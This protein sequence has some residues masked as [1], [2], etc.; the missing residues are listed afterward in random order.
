MEKVINLGSSGVGTGE[1]L[2]FAANNLP[3]SG[4]VL[5][6]WALSELVA[7]GHKNFTGVPLNYLGIK[8]SEIIGKI[9]GTH[10]DHLNILSDSDY[11]ELLNHSDEEFPKF[12]RGGIFTNPLRGIIGEA[13][14]EAVIPLDGKVLGQL[15]DRI[16]MSFYEKS[17]I[18]GSAKRYTGYSSKEISDKGIADTVGKKIKDTF[19][20]VYKV[21]LMY[22]QQTANAVSKFVI[23]FKK[24][25]FMESLV[26]FSSNFQEGFKPTIEMAK[27]YFNVAKNY[28]KVG[29][30]KDIEKVQKLYHKVNL[31]FEKG[32]FYFYRNFRNQ[33][34]RRNQLLYDKLHNWVIRA[35]D[36]L[37]SSFKSFTDNIPGHLSSFGNKIVSAFKSF[38]SKENQDKFEKG[39]RQS[40]K[41]LNETYNN[42]VKSS[43]ETSFNLYHGIKSGVATVKS[44]LQAER[45]KIKENEYQK[46]GH[47]TAKNKIKHFGSGFVEYIGPDTTMREYLTKLTILTGS[48][49]EDLFVESRN[50]IKS[51]IKMINSTSKDSSLN[52]ARFR[53]ITE[54]HFSTFTVR[55]AELFKKFN[56]SNN[57]IG[58][59]FGARNNFLK[60]ILLKP[61]LSTL[62]KSMPGIGLLAGPLLAG[63][64]M[65]NKDWRGANIELM[66]GIAGGMGIAPVSAMLSAILHK[67][68]FKYR[69]GV[70][71][72]RGIDLETDRE[73]ALED[74]DG[75][76]GRATARQRDRRKSRIKHEREFIRTLSK[77]TPVLG[78]FAGA[79]LSAKRLIAGDRFGAAA[80]LASGVAGGIGMT[81][82]SL[83]ISGATKIP[84]I[85]NYTKAGLS[86][87]DVALKGIL[88]TRYKEETTK[89]VLKFGLK[90]IPIIGAVAGGAFAARRL[91]KGDKVGAGL[92]LVGGL[93]GGLGGPLGGAMIEGA[94]PFINFMAT[95]AAGFIQ[96]MEPVASL[97]KPISSVWESIGGLGGIISG[98]FNIPFDLS[99]LKESLDTYFGVISKGTFLGNIIDNIHTGTKV[100]SH[101]IGDFFSSSVGLMDKGIQGMSEVVRT[102]FVNLFDNNMVKGSLKFLQTFAPISNFFSATGLGQLSNLALGP[103]DFFR[104]Q[105]ED[106]FGK[107]NKKS[108]GDRFKNFI[109]SFGEKKGPKISM[110]DRIRNYQQRQ[111]DI[112]NED[113]LKI[114]KT[115]DGPKQKVGFIPSFLGSIAGIDKSGKLSNAISS[116]MNFMNKEIKFPSIGKDFSFGKFIKSGRTK[117]D[118]F[119]RNITEIDNPVSEWG[120]SDELNTEQT[121]SKQKGSDKLNT[122]QTSSK[123]KGSFKFSMPKLRMPKISHP[124]KNFKFPDI[125]KFSNKKLDDFSERLH[126]INNPLF[127]RLIGDWDG[128]ERSH[129]INNPLFK[130]LIG[131]WDGD[132]KLSTDQT[133]SE[134]KEKTQTKP[135]NIFKLPTLSSL[136]KFNLL[137]SIRTKVKDFDRYVTVID[138]PIGEWG[139]APLPQKKQIPSKQKDSF[140]L[141]DMKKWFYSISSLGKRDKEEQKNEARNRLR[142]KQRNLD[143]VGAPRYMGGVIPLEEDASYLE[144]PMKESVKEGKKLGEKVKNF[145]ASIRESWTNGID[146]EIGKRFDAASEAGIVGS[147]SSSSTVGLKGGLRSLPFLSLA[148]STVFAGDRLNKGDFR[149]A[150]LEMMIGLAGASGSDGG[151]FIEELRQRDSAI[152]GNI[153]ETKETEPKGTAGSIIK[154]WQKSGKEKRNKEEKKKKKPNELF[155]WLKSGVKNTGKTKKKTETSTEVTPKTNTTTTQTTNVI[156]D[157]DAQVRDVTIAT[158]SGKGPA[159]ITKDSVTNVTPEKQKGSQSKFT[160]G[161]IFGKFKGVP[162]KIKQGILGPLFS[163]IIGEVIGGAVT[164]EILRRASKKASVK[165]TKQVAGKGFGG[166]LK[167]LFGGI[168][169]WL[170]SSAVIKGIKGLF[171]AKAAKTVGVGV[172]GVAGKGLTFAAMG[173]GLAAVA[174]GIGT[175]VAAI[176]TA[177]AWLIALGVAALTGGGL[178]LNHIS[179]EKRDPNIQYRKGMPIVPTDYS[180]R[181]TN[182]SNSS[183]KNNNFAN[184]LLNIIAPPAYASEMSSGTL[185]NLTQR[186]KLIAQ[187]NASAIFKEGERR[188]TK[189]FFGSI[190]NFFTSLFSNSSDELDKNN[191]ATNIQS[192]APLVG[193]DRLKSANVPHLRGEGPHDITM[194]ELIGLRT[195]SELEGTLHSD[196]SRTIV[197]GGLAS[198][199]NDHPRKLTYV[200]GLGVYSDAAGYGQFLSPTWDQFGY[201]NFGE[202]NQAQAMVSL[203]HYRGLGQPLSD[204]MLH[205]IT[206]NQIEQLSTEWASVDGGVHGQTDYSFDDRFPQEYTR[207]AQRAIWELDNLPLEEIRFVPHPDSMI[208]KSEDAPVETQPQNNTVVAPVIN[209]TSTTPTGGEFKTSYTFAPL[210]HESSI[211]WAETFHL[212]KLGMG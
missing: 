37:E 176:S 54:S 206:S 146:K 156:V 101:L 50:M 83:A 23:A 18:K 168:A 105:G 207:Q 175:V 114:K 2:A 173:K 143:R 115:L 186:D 127:K 147:I 116:S 67:R 102:G 120:G 70:R 98:V 17:N 151:K 77:A 33:L 131:E 157:E 32:V 185:N 189:G 42:V 172:A 158:D 27:E 144:Q 188:N 8:S 69:K 57:R 10:K 13:G 79:R 161:K 109:W 119:D 94:V 51:G 198:N 26:K 16:V 47:G 149:G 36:S 128:D 192:N 5:G 113:M 187:E 56:Q 208:F 60:D 20:E 123:Q 203:M 162:D 196:G 112:E 48:V 166:L 66:S 58:K 129:S 99:A 93:A 210:R 133:P 179:G 148:L 97:L 46:F 4:A 11:I 95:E 87:A 145:F 212:Q 118:K 104:G 76:A 3:I 170:G 82:L 22:I 52:F 122:D 180:S 153:D 73:L 41:R 1:A 28:V 12:A 84:N 184:S 142:A 134:Q 15:A 182:I 195:I 181:K 193:I 164:G 21:P 167:G 19:M 49:V 171:A 165:A 81:P 178:Y 154:G 155:G 43:I 111:L 103:L 191:S 202:A 53:K 141:P 126:S 65:A 201:S 6:M 90:N 71:S 199:V 24:E 7:R 44:Y 86:S 88:G 96:S 68:D 62:A 124:I 132:E 61:G 163:D 25:K 89:A 177:P 150:G 100:V 205:S 159:K 45:S 92:E 9:K 40:V 152:M 110:I 91:A 31:Q 121:S 140:K 136:K 59:A 204:G 55:S 64:R 74:A 85:K 125:I 107:R 130:R 194:A 197:G 209:N 160:L 72:I 138:N 78:I 183:S 63:Q 135:K 169:T 80:E 34:S 211:A 200:P 30:K 137:K 108:V 75:D 38:T 29:Y 35:S 190:G 39:V 14:P 117:F 139:T 106:P 174:A